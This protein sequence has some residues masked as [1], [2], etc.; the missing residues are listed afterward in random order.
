MEHILF[1]N[2]FWENDKDGKDKTDYTREYLFEE[3]ADVEGWKTEDDVP[4][5]RVWDELYTQSEQIA[6]WEQRKKS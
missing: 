2:Y 3:Y 5:G 4:E 1:T 6:F